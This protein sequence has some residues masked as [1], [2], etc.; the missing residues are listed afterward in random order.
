M[1]YYYMPLFHMAWMKVYITVWSCSPNRLIKL[2]DSPAQAQSRESLLDRL[3][4]PPFHTCAKEEMYL[5]C[6][7][8]K[9]VFSEQ[10]DKTQYLD[11]DFRI[12][13]TGHGQ[14]LVP[15]MTGQVPDGDCSPKPE[16]SGLN[17]CRTGRDMHCIG[18]GMLFL[19]QCI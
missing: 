17:D 15:P 12:S 9:S 11:E 19:C 18:E 13:I 8:Q 16:S 2:T 10:K 5:Q 14:S 3:C 6:D 1:T 4:S 7:V